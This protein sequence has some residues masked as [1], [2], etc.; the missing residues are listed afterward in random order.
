MS[1]NTLCA[2]V[3]RITG[4]KITQIALSGKR[5][6]RIAQIRPFWSNLSETNLKK[7]D[8]IRGF[9]VPNVRTYGL[10]ID[11]PLDVQGEEVRKLRIKGLTPRV[12]SDSIV[13]PYTYGSGFV[14]KLFDV[15]GKDEIMVREKR[16][17][18]EYS[19]HGTL[20]QDRLETEVLTALA[21]GPKTT[22]PILGFGEFDGLT[23]NGGPVGFAIYGMSR[24]EDDRMAQTIKK[25]ADAATRNGKILLPPM[26]GAAFMTGARLREMHEKGF[27]H[28]YPHLDNFAVLPNEDV[29][30][31]DLDTAVRISNIP[32]ELRSAFLY[33]DF[34]RLIR[35]YTY[36]VFLEYYKRVDNQDGDSEEFSFAFLRSLMPLFM[37]FLNGY[38][39][40]DTGIELSDRVKDYKARWESGKSS[41][42]GVI[43]KKMEEDFGLVDLEYEEGDTEKS[44]LIT[45]LQ[46]IVDLYSA[47][48]GTTANL[49]D[50]CRYK[51][52][53][54]L[55]EALRTVAKRLK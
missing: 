26:Y 52:F 50:Y 36:N 16:S 47:P 49:N 22:D 8:L 48:E 18:E 51:E 39:G 10:S 6:C 40:S 55:Y 14:E 13:A 28:R 15:I 29:R 12:G 33:L 19:A 41:E 11:I 20:S 37:Y 30:I 21:L 32:E 25:L 54:P 1:H 34:S 31:V 9:D 44:T 3:S 7:L 53:G 17:A 2:E 45:S 24:I 5:S 43:W 38:F 27:F 35:D 23:F 42:Q 4:S 46:P